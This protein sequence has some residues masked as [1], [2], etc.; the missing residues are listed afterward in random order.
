MSVLDR[1]AGGGDDGPGWWGE[2][3]GR[4]CS[5]VNILPG[6]TT[7]IQCLLSKCSPLSTS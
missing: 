6:G 3:C 5:D 2:W 7:S 4:G 1:S